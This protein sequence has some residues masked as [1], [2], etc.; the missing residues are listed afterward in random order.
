MAVS[1]A[2]SQKAFLKTVT[3]D[4]IGATKDSFKPV[5]LDAVEQAL[6]ELATLFKVLADKKL[7][8]KDAVNTGL[9]A[10]SIQFTEVEYFNQTYSV[11]IK[12]L[13]YY[14]FVDKGV[15]GVKG[16]GSSPYRF[17]NLHVSKKMQD[18]IHKWVVREGLK[19]RTRDALKKAIGQERKGKRFA[20]ADKTKGLAWLIAR[21]IKLKGLKPTKFWTDTEIE[22]RKQMHEQMGNHF[23]VAI[24]NELTR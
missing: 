19:V 8:V 3:L 20:K 12:V 13:D 7:S 18:A 15:K 23:A 4:K 14:K 17:K 6:I 5:K 24:I 21:K 1:I 9:L 10:D 22:V 2:Q 16:G 11:S